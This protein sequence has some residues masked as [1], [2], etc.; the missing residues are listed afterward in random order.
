MQ[1]NTAEHLKVRLI[2]LSCPQRAC[3]VIALSCQLL[4]CQCGVHIGVPY[5][6]VLP[7]QESRKN[8]LRDFVD[9]AGPLGVSHFLILTATDTA[10]YL[11]IAKTPRVRLWQ[12][13]SILIG[14][15]S[16][17]CSHITCKTQMIDISPHSHW[18]DT[19][20]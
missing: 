6:E 11:R 9:I 1:P 17:E 13:R 19:T 15:T 7:A 3:E 14:L 5:W 12:S 2:S 18:P 4:L 16:L 20:A 8:Q 10:A